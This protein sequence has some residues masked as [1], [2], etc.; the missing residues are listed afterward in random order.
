MGEPTLAEAMEKLARGQQGEPPAAVSSALGVAATGSVPSPTAAVP[1]AATVAVP[2]PAAAAMCE[3]G[4]SVSI[5]PSFP[6]PPPSV[7]I[8][9]ATAPTAAAPFVSA[10][11][12]VSDSGS[13]KRRRLPSALACAAAARAVHAPGA[14]PGE[15][16]RVDVGVCSEAVD[17]AELCD[18]DSSEGVTSVERHTDDSDRNSIGNRHSDPDVAGDAEEGGGLPDTE[19][20]AVIGG[21]LPIFISESSDDEA[22]FDDSGCHSSSKVVRLLLT[23]VDL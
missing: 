20:V 6:P 17:E 5:P 2:V 7:S 9:I 19:T 8:F 10:A 4:P 16:P 13:W 18:L 14:C 15:R 23:H 11:D 12:G 21:D 3:A 22:G 1:T